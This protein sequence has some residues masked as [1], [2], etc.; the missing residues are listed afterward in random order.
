MERALPYLVPSDNSKF[1]SFITTLSTHGPYNES[2]KNYK[3]LV[4]ISLKNC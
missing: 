4:Q 1:Y 3:N 2:G